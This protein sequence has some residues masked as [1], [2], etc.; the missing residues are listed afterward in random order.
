MT[1]NPPNVGL[2]ASSLGFALTLEPLEANGR[3]YLGTFCA[4]E[5]PISRESVEYFP[6][7]E[8]AAQAMATGE[9]SQRD[10]F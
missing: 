5:G 8:A 1:I 6:S 7:Q 9:W 10:H 4:E 3:W 2:L